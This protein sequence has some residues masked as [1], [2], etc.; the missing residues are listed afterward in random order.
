MTRLAVEAL[1]AG[2]GR[3]EVLHGVDL[4]VGPGQLVALVGANGAGKTTL[5]RVTS[6]LLPARGGRVQLDGKD[7]TGTPAERLA[8]MGVAHVPENRLVFP[9][10]T[11]MDNLALG[12]YARRRTGISDKDYE[13]ILDLF[14]RL[15][16]RRG[17]TAG[18]LSGGEQQMLAIGR[19]LMAQP[20][21]L[22]LD[23]PSLGLAPKL[24]GEIFGVLA[25]LRD[26]GD[27]GVVL[28]E[29]NARAALRI[30]DR[31]VVLDRGRV[32][33]MGTPDEL[34]TDARV[35]AAYLG[36]GYSEV[37]S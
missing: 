15:A 1:S 10:M 19:G 28:V 32:S 9:G 36:R 6:G 18:T 33:L 5:L 22:L 4:S 34:L 16:D 24:V 27:L 13:A 37:T 14:L 26:R 8:G 25:T 31:A 35:Q 17:Q 29:Q 2:Y 21:L 12:A 3:I 7:V 20:R 11:V 23:E 30:A